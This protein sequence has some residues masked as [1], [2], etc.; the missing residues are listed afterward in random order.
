[1]HGACWPKYTH[2]EA[3][4]SPVETGRGRLPS[5]WSY[6]KT[7]LRAS[8]ESSPARRSA[9]FVTQAA[10]LL[11]NNYLPMVPMR[12]TILIAAYLF[13][14][15]AAMAAAWTEVIPSSA[16]KAVVPTDAEL[17]A[18][19][20]G[21]PNIRGVSGPFDEVFS[22]WNSAVFD[23]K[24]GLIYAHGGGHGNYGGNEVYR[25]DLN[26]GTWERITDP[27]P[28]LGEVVAQGKRGKDYRL[29]LD[30]P[31]ST[32]T[33][34]G[35]CYNEDRNS[36]MLLATGIP[37]TPVG[38]DLGYPPN[39]YRWEFEIDKS[40]WGKYQ[41]PG[42]PNQ[43]F[44]VYIPKY[45]KAY[46]LDYGGK[47]IVVDKNWN[48]TSVSTA[49]KAD[50][51]TP[52][53]DAGRDV[54]WSVQS[55]KQ[56]LYRWA[57][58]PD[59]LQFAESITVPTVVK[60]VFGSSPG[61]AMRDGLVWIFGGI[62]VYTFNPDTGE[63]KIHPSE[64]PRMTRVYAK[65]HYWPA[66][67]RFV[68]TTN[69]GAVY[70]LDP[71]Q[72]QGKTVDPNAKRAEINGT[73]YA[74]IAD[75]VKASKDGDTITVYPGTYRE[76]V[77]VDRNNITI[78]A[79]GVVIDGGI[80]RAKA[81]FVQYGDD[82][83]IEG[84][85]A[86]NLAVSGQNAALVRMEPSANNLTLRG[87]YVHDS[88]GGAAVTGKGT[89]DVIVEDSRIERTGYGG[90]AHGIY[91]GTG[92]DR[93][94]I[95]RS[96]FVEGI[97]LGHL[98]KSRAPVTII[99]DSTLDGRGGDH[100]RV[101][102]IPCGGR[103]EIRRSVLRQSPNSDNRDLIAIAVERCQLPHSTLVLEDTRWTATKARSRF[104]TTRQTVDIRC[105]GVNEFKGVDDPCD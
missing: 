13:M 96:E 58:Y 45:E 69:Q 60:N 74:T 73:Q 92:A 48:V 52:V 15:G 35:I 95:R 50:Q 29:P 86:K 36:L 43:G 77:R 84:V 38:G 3:L 47:Q 65:F 87:V 12:L 71:T 68:L 7:P 103:V 20:R 9:I 14:G 24:R 94:I 66:A 44:C 105:H 31:P 89:G 59:R 28:Y 46:G 5:C 91:V 85:E 97:R 16:F 102:D 49:Q 82:L 79:Q 6:R 81:S 32:H 78:K 30:G 76:G 18:F 64:A 17:K 40:T 104:L 2:E 63:W 90:Q 19:S 33:Y 8:A 99:E 80:Y 61:I 22:A 53:Y 100:S 10:G 4:L 21:G 72:L 62:E 98:V 56:R 34:A 70:L 23:A 26:A 93:L 11:R 27:S 83:T 41:A 54:V 88:Q 39:P 1:M 101:I 37:F 67:D 57:V 75:A 51:H 42:L 25:A 55:R